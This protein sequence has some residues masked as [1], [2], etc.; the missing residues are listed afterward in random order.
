MLFKQP[1][2]YGHIELLAICVSFLLFVKIDISLHQEL[3]NVFSQVIQVVLKGTTFWILS[4]T[5]F[6]SLGMQF[7]MKLFFLFTP[8][9]LHHNFPMIPPL[10]LVMILLFFHVQF[11]ITPFQIPFFKPIM[12]FPPL[13]LQTL[14]LQIR[15]MAH[16]QIL[17]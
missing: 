15:I 16:H 9:H 17:H 1:P 2:S 8:F 12:L 11:L 14:F 5:P 13:I 6:M 7:S 10:I 3:K 4:P